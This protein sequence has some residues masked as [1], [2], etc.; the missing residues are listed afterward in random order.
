M[1]D[2]NDTFS[3]EKLMDAAQK[4]RDLMPKQATFL[5]SQYYHVDQTIKVEGK[6]EIFVLLHPET[7]EKVLAE[8][9]KAKTPND[10]VGSNVSIGGIPIFDMDSRP[11]DAVESSIARMRMASRLSAAL[12]QAVAMF[13]ERRRKDKLHDT[14]YDLGVRIHKGLINPNTP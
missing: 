8:T 4:L 9:K 3:F 7:L 10:L 12:N 1:P 5:V 11:D 14:A 13:A 6:D 2:T